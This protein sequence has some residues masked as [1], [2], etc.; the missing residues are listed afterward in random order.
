VFVAVYKMVVD[1]FRITSFPGYRQINVSQ[2]LFAGVV[3]G[4]PI[5]WR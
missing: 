4:L 1:L 5:Y 3:I 2:E